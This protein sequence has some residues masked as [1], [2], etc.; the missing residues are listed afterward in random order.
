MFQYD[1]DFDYS[2]L[3]PW[4]FS[5]VLLGVGIYLSHQ[6]Y[7]RSWGYDFNLN[8]S[9]FDP[10]WEI[11]MRLFSLLLQWPCSFGLWPAA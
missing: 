1:P 7:Q 3:V 6:W 11:I 10:T 4:L 2:V 5:W 8:R 9:Y